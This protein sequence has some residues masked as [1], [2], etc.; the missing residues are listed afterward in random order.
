V[1]RLV[2]LACA[3]LSALAPAAA[4]A[5]IVPGAT[6]DGP[7]ADVVAAQTVQSDVAPDG[8][9]AIAYLKGA[10]AH[11]WVSRLVGGAWSAPEQV[12][13]LPGASSNPRVAVANGGKVVVTFANGGNLHGVVKPSASAP[14]GSATNIGAT[15]AYG[16][17]DL[18]PNGNGYVAVK[19]T[20]VLTAARIEGTTF[21]PV[22]GALN[23]DP[24][25]DAGASDREAKV[26]ANADGS[27]AVI[28]WGEDPGGP[29]SVYVRTI[30]G[31]TVGGIQDAKLASLDGAL[32]TN[33]DVIMP[34]VAMDATGTAWLVFREFFVYGGMNFGRALARPLPPGGSLGTAQV[35]DG[36][37][38]PPT[39]NVE[40]PRVDVNP[41][42][43]GLTANYL[44]TT[45]GVESARLSAGTWTRGIL[46]NAVPNTGTAFATPAVA[47]SG[48]GVVSWGHDP[49]GAGTQVKRILA[50]TNLAGVFGQTLTLSDPAL[51]ELQQ[52]QLTSSPGPSFAVVGYVQG[53]A[54]AGDP[55]RI[56]GAI[57]DL[58]GPGGGGGSP[59]DTTKPK[60]RKLKLSAKRFRIGTKLPSVAAVG[61]GVRIRY[62]LSEAATVTLSFERVTRGRKVG[63]RCVKAKRSNRRRKACK[64]YAAVK[65]ALS[66]ANQA[67]G[68]RSI[69]FEGRLNRRK[70]LKPGVYRLTL[71]AR[72]LAGN[73]SAPLR[74]RVEVLPRKRKR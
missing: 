64:R 24:T 42:G 2:V 40:Y 58:P 27:A 29:G 50:R 7:S 63:K 67:A 54:G 25:K 32:A 45:V 17:V 14:F 30:T 47:E 26:V 49:D 36:L 56:G 74:A 61:T 44:G 51:G 72:D 23:N 34:D 48:Q 38:S 59:P 52:A 21:T 60:L 4:D 9:A 31:T 1:R 55:R 33:T 68:Q 62:T 39:E 6:V 10:T 46:V 20:L 69:R 16:E 3:A 43:I 65:P 66:F 11:V 12:E 28:V 22:A 41:A 5:A 15:G 13:S 18:A 53:G 57:V 37:A 35:V 70:T 73:R 19:A 8:T 71:R